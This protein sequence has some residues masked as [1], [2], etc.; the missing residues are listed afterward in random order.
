MAFESVRITLFQEVLFRP[1]EVA[2]GV[3]V[4]ALGGGIVGVAAV[5]GTVWWLQAVRGLIVVRRDIVLVSARFSL[6]GTGRYVI[7]GLPICLGV[8]FTTWFLQGPLVLLR[9]A[10]VDEGAL[11]QFALAMQ[12]Y[13]LISNFGLATAV[14]AVPVISR[15]YERGDGKDVV[16]IEGMLRAWILGGAA[17][18]LFT[19]G[20]G[21]WLVQAIFGSRYALAG[22]WVG[23]MMW[24]LVPLISGFAVHNV[25]LARTRYLAASATS[26]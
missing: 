6:R 8:V 24:L 14:A 25:L 5:H 17:I 23:P 10:G 13:A 3:A 19:L 9:Q 22:E 12:G 7:R 20:A 26:A 11:G 2:L 16:F 15:A 18:A 21:P 1:F 4:L